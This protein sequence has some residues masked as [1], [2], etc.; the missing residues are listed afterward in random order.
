M[1]VRTVASGLAVV[2]MTGIAVPAALGGVAS[3]KA[4]STAAPTVA[5]CTPSPATVKKL[6]TITGKGLAKATSV[7]IGSKVTVDRSAFKKDLGKKITFEVPKAILK[8]KAYL[9]TVT[10]ASGSGSAMCNFQT[11]PKK[12]HK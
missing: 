5:A 3:A 7:T 8:T 2:A 12:S 6:V 4:P 9:V 11:A 1:K 10:T